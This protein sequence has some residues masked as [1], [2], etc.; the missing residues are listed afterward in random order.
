MIYGEAQKIAGFD[1]EALTNC[2]LPRNRGRSLIAMLCK[3]DA[4]HGRQSRGSRTYL[5]LPP[6][7]QAAAIVKLGKRSSTLRLRL[8]KHPP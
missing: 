5:K 1:R 4:L 3:A 8:A 6:A 7:R 2:H